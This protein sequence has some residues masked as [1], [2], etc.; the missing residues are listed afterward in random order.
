MNCQAVQN[1]I[2]ALP[3]PRQIPDPLRDHVVGCAACQA[4]ARQAARLEA[5]LAQLPAPA[6]PAEKKEAMIDELTQPEPVIHPMA[7]P[8]TRPSF[9]LVAARFLRRNATYVGGL[10][11]AV[12][13]AVG[14]YAL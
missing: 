7:T 4:W 6:A 13:V 14:I 1:K 3:D 5:L 10:A 12:L 2:L 8:A 9:G 11:A